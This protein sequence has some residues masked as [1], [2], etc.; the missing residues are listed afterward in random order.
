MALLSAMIAYL[1]NWS[2]LLYKM[3]FR[4]SVRTQ[5]TT[6]WLPL[7]NSLMLFMRERTCSLINMTYN[8]FSIKGLKQL[9]LFSLFAIVLLAT[10][11]KRPDNELGE[12]LLPGTDDMST[13]QSD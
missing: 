11:C 3:T 7:M 8:S 5:K 2:N 4:C 13:L 1:Q 12:S 10:S 6:Q 9:G